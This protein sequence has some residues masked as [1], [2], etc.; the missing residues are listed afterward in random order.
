MVTTTSTVYEY[1]KEHYS[2]SEQCRTAR[3][4]EVENPWLRKAYQ[5]NRLSFSLLWHHLVLVTYRILTAMSMKTT[6]LWYCAIWFDGNRQTFQRFSLRA[7]IS[8]TFVTFYE[9]TRCI[10]E[11]TSM[12]SCGRLL[13]FWRNPARWKRHDHTESQTRGST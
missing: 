12:W 9:T 11:D 8:E 7:I 6:L 2:M 3:E 4:D 10:P 1:V 13:A 5:N